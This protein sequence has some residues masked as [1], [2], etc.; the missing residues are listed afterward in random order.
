MEPKMINLNEVAYGLLLN[1]ANSWIG[2][3]ESPTNKGQ[4]V[5]LFQKVVD[6]KAQ[7][8]A[9]CM[10]FVQWCVRRAYKQFAIA[11]PHVSGYLDNVLFASEHCLTVWHKTPA[12]ARTTNPYP[13]CI[14]IWQ[15]GDTSSGHTGIV[16]AMLPGDKMA[17]IEGNTGSGQ[18]VVREGDGVYSRVRSIKG[19]GNMKVVGFLEPYVHLVDSQEQA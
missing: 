2:T 10:A 4:L 16:V 12:L 7:G 11:H 13:G 15:H 17:T 19:E 5:E 18:G 8:E 6:G 14:V 9:W 1:E 3:K